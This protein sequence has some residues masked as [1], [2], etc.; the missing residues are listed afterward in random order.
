MWCLQKASIKP[1]DAE[2]LQ[3]KEK[4]YILGKC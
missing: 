3:I 1:N 4:N 2:R